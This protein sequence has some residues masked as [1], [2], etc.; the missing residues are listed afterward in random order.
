MITVFASGFIAEKPSLQL[1]GAKSAKCEFTVIWA[2]PEY[3]DG[4]WKTAWERATFTAWDTEAERV[5]SRLD[6]GTRVTCTGLQET[7]SWQGTDGSKRYRTGYRLTSWV[8]EFQ[9][10]PQQG[11]AE[12]RGNAP[13]QA[14]R[15][16]Q[17]PQ[18]PPEVPRPAQAPAPQRHH[19][20]R[21]DFGGDGHFDHQSQHQ[22]AG[23]SFD[24]GFGEPEQDF[25]RM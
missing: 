5:A 20:S 3:R 4:E 10:R 17:R 8:V 21:E 18:R 15:Q 6:K 19:E 12:P 25:I 1:V 24:D 16:D 22:N 11:N 7:S 13:S 23:S 2:K 9:Q 14:P